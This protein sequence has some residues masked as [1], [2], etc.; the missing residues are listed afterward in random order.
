MLDLFQPPVITPRPTRIVLALDVEPAPRH[1]WAY[2]PTIAT[3]A[4]PVVQRPTR[5]DRL[6][7]RRAY[8]AAY[9]ARKEAA[10][11]KRLRLP[12]SEWTEAQKVT[13][14]AKQREYYQ[15]NKA[16]IAERERQRYLAMT[17]EVRAAYNARANEWR[18]ENRERANAATR[19][20]KAAKRK[21]R[22]A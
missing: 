19:A 9:R 15:A 4:P 2:V 6:A 21:A 5:E 14:R 11:E 22:N 12:Y 18:R 13:R 10:G 17:P 20:R 1:A 3:H 8:D 7:K 16:A